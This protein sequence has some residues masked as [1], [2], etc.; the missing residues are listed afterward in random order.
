MKTIGDNIKAIRKEKKITQEELAKKCGLSKNG[1]WNYEN[2]KREPGIETLNDIASALDTTIEK[3]LEDTNIHYSKTVLTEKEIESI[4]KLTNTLT[5]P[6]HLKKIEEKNKLKE[7][8]NKKIIDYL[9]VCNVKN[10]NDLAN[11][12]LKHIDLE[13]EINKE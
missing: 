7:T 13:I 12:I 8:L 9:E 4:R 6:E 3:L 1:L 10:S 5:N 2:N 11:N